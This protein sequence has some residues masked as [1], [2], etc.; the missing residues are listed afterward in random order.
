M[1]TKTNGNGAQGATPVNK[2]NQ[3]AETTTAP[4]VELS[5]LVVGPREDEKPKTEAEVK[6]EPKAEPKTE[7]NKDLKAFVSLEQRKRNAELFDILLKKHET[8]QSAKQ[9][10]DA[11]LIG[12]DENSQTISLKDKNNNTFTTGNPIV[13]AQCIDVIKDHINKQC[14]TIE[15]EIMDFII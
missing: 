2:K 3:G 10:M 11:F 1:S 13:I 7:P 14:G 12:T 8:A 5:N 15:T 9:K 6:T 4:K